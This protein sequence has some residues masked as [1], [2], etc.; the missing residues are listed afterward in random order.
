MK[1]NYYTCTLKSDIVLNSSL[2]TEGN[3]SSLD[4]IPGSN[5]LGIVASKIYDKL[6]NE[7]ALDLFHNGKVKFGDATISKDKQHSLPMPFSYF[8]D[9]ME[10]KIGENPIYIHHL[11]DR[12]N[13]PKKKDNKTVAQL[14]QMRGGYL[15]A[16]HQIVKEVAKTFSLKSA[17][18]RETRNS[19]EGAMFGFDAIEK[20]QEFIFSITFEKDEYITIVNSA[21]IGV[22]RLGKSKNAEYG[23]VDIQEI[24]YVKAVISVQHEGF[25]LVYAQS[26]LYIIDEFGQA[27]LQPTAIDLGIASGQI[28]WEKSQV[29]AFSY[30]PWNGKR[31]T[32]STQR[33]CIAK[34]SIF[35]VEQGEK[36]V[37]TEGF[38]GGFQA[39]GL[40]K[41]LYNPAF[42]VGDED[43]KLA[44][45]LQEFKPRE[46][47][48][49]KKPASSRLTIFL[50]QQLNNKLKEKEIS[51]QILDTIQKLTS[52]KSS[53]IKISASQWGGIRSY[54]SNTK[55]FKE[56]EE[57]LFDKDKGYLTH[58]VADEKHWGINGNL[59]KFKEIFEDHKKHGTVFVAKFAAEMA[60]ENKRKEKEHGHN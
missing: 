48:K 37:K 31:K 38:V 60:K 41:V 18:D 35:Y 24:T 21:L 32:S 3:M 16:N 27:T 15:L 20:G 4:Y 10:K 30:S 5:F 39:E 1:T 2:A 47:E 57:L 55:D 17:Q 34:G 29:R 49:Q 43:A 56:L 23:Q 7:K 33:H 51:A 54:A 46:A 6:E 19:K 45:Q 40:G 58:G 9:K 8:M 52:D 14:K 36:L 25:N 59:K 13:R 26:N 28:N 22:Q 53:L 11:I 12:E 42:L 44:N 50:T